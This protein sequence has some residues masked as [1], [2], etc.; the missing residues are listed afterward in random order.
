MTALASP[1]TC[2]ALRA[3]AAGLQRVAE[4][5]ER[6]GARSLP[7]QPVRIVTCADDAIDERRHQI[8]T[9]YY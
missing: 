2:A 5:L 7:L 8:F 4:R 1:W 3:V 6:R 9:R